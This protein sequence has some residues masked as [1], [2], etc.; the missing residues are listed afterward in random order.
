MSH[1]ALEF[2]ATGAQ[3]HKLIGL[4]S[5]KNQQHDLQE[6]TDEELLWIR[7]INACLRACGAG[8]LD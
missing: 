8:I 7:K 5:R 2:I 1:P 3:Q 6:L 4:T